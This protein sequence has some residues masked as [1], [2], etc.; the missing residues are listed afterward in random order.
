MP[1]PKSTID[2][3]RKSLP[4][5]AILEIY[6]RLNAKGTEISYG[7]VTFFLRT[8]DVNNDEVINEALSYLE[9]EKAKQRQAESR[10]KNIMSEEKAN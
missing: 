3:V 8:P 7:M 10:L 6:K 9:E 5:G 1:Y 4:H 2:S